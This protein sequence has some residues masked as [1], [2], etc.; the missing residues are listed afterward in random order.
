M[1]A[2]DE[3]RDWKYLCAHILQPSPATNVGELDRARLNR[4][5]TRRAAVEW[6]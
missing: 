1:G 3:L 4:G 6:V 5:A 2:V